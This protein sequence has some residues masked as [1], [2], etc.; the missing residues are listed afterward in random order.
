MIIKMITIT[1]GLLFATVMAL[2]LN[3]PVLHYEIPESFHGW[4]VV[5]YLEAECVNDGNGNEITINN[6]GYGCTS[7]VVTSEFVRTKWFLV[8]NDGD[9]VGEL[10]EVPWDSNKKG[11]W[12]HA[13]LKRNEKGLLKEYFYIGTETQLGMDWDNMP[14][15]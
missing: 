1:L 15:K 2:Y 14:I 12:A 13:I 7:R 6:D 11:V 9:K 8:D 4:V 5:S 10:T 3:S